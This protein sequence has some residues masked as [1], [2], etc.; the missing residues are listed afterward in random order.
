[1]ETSIGIENVNREINPSLGS[2]I[3]DVEGSKV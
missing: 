3:F 2:E 1:M